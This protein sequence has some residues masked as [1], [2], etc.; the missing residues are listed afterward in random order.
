M[1]SL[2]DPGDPPPPETWRDRLLRRDGAAT[3]AIARLPHPRWVTI[4]YGVLSLSANYGVVWFAI[5]AVPWLAG[6]AHGPRTFVFVAG[7]V[8]V[9]EWVTFAVKLVFTRSRPAA[10]DPTLGG[11]IPLPRSHSFPSS[12]ASMGMAGMITVSSLYPVWLPG[13]A[14]LTALLCFSRIYLGVHYV[15]DVLVGIVLGGVLGFL[16]VLLFRALT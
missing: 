1:P 3:E 6:A 10:V 12:H 16:F 8:L 14:L 7:S 4:P 5:A 13:L 11:H 2:V 15:L 9:T